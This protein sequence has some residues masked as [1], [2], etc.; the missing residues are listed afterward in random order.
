M[1]PFPYYRVPGERYRER[2]RE[3]YGKKRDGEGE[4]SPEGWGGWL[5]GPNTHI[6]L[7]K[8][9]AGLS[10]FMNPMPWGTHVV[11]HLYIEHWSLA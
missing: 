8:K 1:I 11:E 9:K 6:F 10:R 4:E 7:P 3:K 5:L 2:T